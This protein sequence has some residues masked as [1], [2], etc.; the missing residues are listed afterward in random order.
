MSVQRNPWY[1]EL[2][3]IRYLPDTSWNDLFAS[4]RE[5]QEQRRTAH[6][7]D[8][9]VAKRHARQFTAALEATK[10]EKKMEMIKG[11]RF[12]K[13]KP[14]QLTNR[15]KPTEKEIL[16]RMARSHRT[17][18]EGSQLSAITNKT[19]MNSLFSGE[20]GEERQLIGGTEAELKGRRGRAPSR[21]ALARVVFVDDFVI[22]GGFSQEDIKMM[23]ERKKVEFQI[24]FLEWHHRWC[25]KPQVNTLE[26]KT[27]DDREHVF[28]FI[29]ELEAAQTI[30]FRSL[31][32]KEDLGAASR[33]RDTVLVEHNP[34]KPVSGDN[35]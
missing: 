3:N 33:F 22:R 17:P 35:E 32:A 27:T 9:I 12:N 29:E 1:G 25:F 10:L 28:F 2:W 21:L 5:E 18:P 19:F 11:K 13:R 31:Q 7:R 6:D 34:T 8:V 30:A 15:Q 26:C 14:M 4:E 24:M 16:E 23:G 20:H